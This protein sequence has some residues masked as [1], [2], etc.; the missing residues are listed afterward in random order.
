MERFLYRISDSPYAK[1]FVLK[2]ASLFLVWKGQSYRVTRDADFLVLDRM[3]IDQVTRLFRK[4]CE[5][6]TTAADG[7]SFSSESVKCVAIREEN[8]YGGLR[9][10]FSGLLNK[11]RIPMQIDIGF[12]D[13]ITPKAEVIDFPTLLDAPAPRLRAYPRY[14]VVAE[15]FEIMV[16]LG[17]A[18]SRMKDFFDIWLVSRLFEFDGAILSKA[19][20]NTFQRRKTNLPEGVPLAFTDEFRKDSQKQTQWKAF[21]KRAKPD[22]KVGNFDSIVEEIEEFLL[23]VLQAGD[24]LRKTWSKGGPWQ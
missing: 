19:I 2:G 9:V 7:I 21:V 24:L 15:K 14:A 11:V 22:I 6:D 5:A 20:R 16:S 13:E 3:D 4:L 12:G 18:N 17:M 1:K 23:P 8:I 10:T